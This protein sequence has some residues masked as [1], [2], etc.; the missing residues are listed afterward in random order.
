[1]D[2]AVRPQ[3][4]RVWDWIQE[5]AALLIPGA[6]VALAL[7]LPS[8]RNYLLWHVGSEDIYYEL[9]DGFLYLSDIALLAAIGAWLLT[10][11]PRRVPR[12]PVWLTGA[13]LA[14]TAWAT[15]SILWSPLKSFAA[16]QAVRLWLLFLLYLVIATTPE[17][18]GALMWGL[19]TSGALQAGLGIAQFA[20]QRTF[21]MR[22][23]GEIVMR[24]E[25]SGASVITVN[26]DPVLRAYGLTQH[27][28]LLGG[29]LT[30]ATLIAIGLAAGR[31]GWPSLIAGAL[32]AV[33]FA[34][35]LL[36][37]SRAAWL[38][39]AVGAAA[40]AWLLFTRRREVNRRAIAFLALGLLLIGAVF[41]ATQWPLLMP[42]LGLT[43]EGVEIRSADERSGLEASA[44]VL[45]REHPW[46]GV[47]YGNFAWALWLRQPEAIRA[48]PIYQPVHRVPLLAAAEL[49]LPGA[50]LWLT[51][52]A[53]PWLA[54]WRRRA[55]WPGGGVPAGTA[56]GI[57]ATVA[58]L[59]V[60]GWFDF[61][62]WFSP[63]G[64]MLA[65]ICWALWAQTAPRRVL[66][67][68]G[69]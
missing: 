14:L 37:F 32:A 58:A 46:V 50:L 39:F 64:R 60:V 63:Q 22:N 66:P 69:G 17:A 34:G 3:P 19:A 27:P 18:R 20:A 5:Q 30:V 15:L 28:N 23:L 47:G 54:M 6:L 53:G 31:K 38:G 33:S 21:G 68:R 11:F 29:F 8:W 2:V 51:L 65:W 59:T 25:W 44:W 56:A 26:G 62:P 40:G 57:A 1:M 41:A 36:T 12:L 61:Y 43:V 13:L 55:T 48:Y 7:T 4:R 49:G 52:A 45:I 35:L 16:Y 24:P 67:G 42:R 10:P 9:R